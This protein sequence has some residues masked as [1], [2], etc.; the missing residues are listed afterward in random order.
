MSFFIEEAWA[1]GAAPQGAGFEGARASS[2]GSDR[3]S[4]EVLPL[5]RGRGNIPLDEASAAI[6]SL[7]DAVRSNHGQAACVWLRAGDYNVLEGLYG[8]QVGTEFMGLVENR[9][10]VKSAMQSLL[11]RPLKEE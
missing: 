6:S 11:S 10:D 8:H 3:R 5:A 2:P 9:L 1:Q 7:L 4:A